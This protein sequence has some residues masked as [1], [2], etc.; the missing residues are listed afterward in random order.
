MVRHPQPDRYFR[1]PSQGEF[2]AP[3]PEHDQRSHQNPRNRWTG[4]D[5]YVTS[6]TFRRVTFCAQG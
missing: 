3:N 4:Q 2:H 1:T 5:K 6:L